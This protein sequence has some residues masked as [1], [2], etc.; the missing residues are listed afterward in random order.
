M[1]TLCVYTH[2]RTHIYVMYLYV[3]HVACVSHVCVCGICVWFMYVVHVCVVWCV[4]VCGLNSHETKGNRD[5]AIIIDALFSKPTLYFHVY[6]G[7]I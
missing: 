6:T 1:Y 3:V 5:V 2:M 4:C 7:E